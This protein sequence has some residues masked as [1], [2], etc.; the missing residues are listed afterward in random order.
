MPSKSESW[1]HSAAENDLAVAQHDT[2]GHGQ[3]QGHA[4]AS[5]FQCDR[6]RQIDHC[7][8]LHQRD[9]RQ[10]VTFAALLQHALEDLIDAD[11]RHDQFGWRFEGGREEVGV[12]TGSEVLKPAA[13][14]DDV[15]RRSA[16]RGTSVSMPRKKPRICRTDFT[17]TSSTRSPYWIAWTF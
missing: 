13:R 9:R 7:A 12:R 2:V 11:G 1:V 8:L 6:Q 5:R 16:S 10:R 4:R 15:H 17:G 3:S 14:V